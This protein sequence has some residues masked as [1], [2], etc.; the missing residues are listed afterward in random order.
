[1]VQ[2][3]SSVEVL[4]V[5][6]LPFISVSKVKKITVI[7]CAC[8]NPSTMEIFPLAFSLGSG[9][10]GFKKKKKKAAG[11]CLIRVKAVQYGTE[12]CLVVSW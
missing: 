5:I 4:F 7:S 10:R 11:Y 3:N 2:N 6:T 1:M 9:K 8:L 12:Q